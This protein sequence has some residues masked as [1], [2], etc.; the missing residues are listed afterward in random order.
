MSIE[1]YGGGERVQSAAA[2]LAM[3]S[4]LKAEGHAVLLPIPTTKDKKHITNTDIPL[5]DALCN[6]RGGSII[7]GWGLTEDFKTRAALLGGRVLELSGDEEFVSENAYFTAIGAVGHILKTSRKAP[8]DMS[9][10]IVGYG[11]IGRMLTEM[12]LYF[13]GR[14][15]VYTSK[16][17]TRIKLGECGIQT[18]DSMDI[19]GG[20]QDFSDIDVLINTAPADMTAAFPGRKIPE[21]LRVI[22]LASGNNFIGVEG[23]EHLPSLPERMYPQSA[24]GAYFRAVKRFISQYED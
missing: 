4:S 20:V 5:T 24:G 13:G 11:R 10:A 8:S 2:L 18:C 7:A 14:L 9:F 22:E 23:V 6:V 15:R 3:G 17:S 19:Y 12:L 1:T 21:G 16:E